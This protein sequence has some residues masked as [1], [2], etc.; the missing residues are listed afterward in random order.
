MINVRRIIEKVE[1]SFQMKLMRDKRVRENEKKK[2][3]RAKNK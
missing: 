2:G 1:K 3:G